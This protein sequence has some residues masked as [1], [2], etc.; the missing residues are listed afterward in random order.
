MLKRKRWSFSSINCFG[1]CKKMFYLT[2]ILHYKQKENAFALWGTY[3]HEILEAYY[4]G[5]LSMFELGDFYKQYYKMFVIKKFPKNKY[6]D[7]D[8][9]YYEAGLK[10][11]ES[12]DDDFSEYEVVGIEQ[13][14]NTK[15]GN[16]RFMGFIDLILKDKDGNYIIVDHKSK[17]KFKDD[18]EKT[19]YALQLYLYSKYI[20]ETYGKFPVELKFNMFRAGEVVSIPFDEKEYIKALHWAETTIDEIFE[21]TDWIDMITT[22][23][24]AQDKDPNDRKYPDFFCSELCSVRSGCEMSKPS[25]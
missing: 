19:H 16:Y 1:E 20:Y 6:R 3:C 24:V 8:V 14:I 7:L 5:Q 15:I 10:Y 13:Q 9:M 25:T 4:R 2:Y 11:F 23:C 17:S 22:K 21:E 12:F 18:N